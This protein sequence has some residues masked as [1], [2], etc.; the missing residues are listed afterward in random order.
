MKTLNL[1][2]VSESELY[3]M[4]TRLLFA[5]AFTVLASSGLR[6]QNEYDTAKTYQV[7]KNDGTDYLGKIL[8]SDE[9][10][11]LIQTNTVGRLIIPKHEIKSIR[12]VNPADIGRGGYL[13][14]EPF[15]T[16][17][18]FTPNGLPRGK[19]NHYAILNWWG[20]DVEFAIGNRF[21]FGLM[22][23]W[24]PIPMIVNAKYSIKLAPKVHLGLGAMAGT[25]NWAKPRRKGVLPYGAL[26]FGDRKNN[27]SLTGGYLSVDDV[28]TTGSQAMFSVAG[29]TKVSKKVS[30]VFD[31]FIIPG[32]AEDI[33]G[34]TALLNPALRFQGKT[35]DRSFQ[36]G[37]AGFMLDDKVVPFPIPFISWLRA[38]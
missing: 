5:L 30:F 37:I 14:E 23:L 34:T 33:I 27:I 21:S 11:I 4:M 2:S 15:A 31:S 3:R 17:H 19:G 24:V 16:R 36:F 9:R 8:R 12:E 20:P 28:G 18:Y 7:I 10:E 6:A 1:T 32:D 35:D 13:G 22:T 25:G 38:F 26:T 29:M